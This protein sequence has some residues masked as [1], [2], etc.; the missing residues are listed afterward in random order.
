LR[1]AGAGCQDDPDALRSGRLYDLEAGINVLV[2]G[3]FGLYGAAKYLHAVKEENGVNVIFF[4]KNI[5]LLG[6]TY[7]F[8][9]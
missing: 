4:K 1:H 9:L 6:F 2:W 5:I 3:K 8:S 7:N